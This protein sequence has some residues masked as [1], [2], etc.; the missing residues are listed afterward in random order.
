MAK[1]LVAFM[2]EPGRSAE[3]AAVNVEIA[4]G[5]WQSAITRKV[6][7]QSSARLVRI[8]TGLR[9]SHIELERLTQEAGQADPPKLEENF[10]E[11]G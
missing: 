10:R 6:E 7:T 4:L 1:V 2:S 9:N 3:M 11:P 5:C 8:K